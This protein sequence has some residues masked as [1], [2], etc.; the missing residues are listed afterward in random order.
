MQTQSSVQYVSL[1]YFVC[2]QW[3]VH[4]VYIHRY[5]I[6]HGYTL[7]W[8]LYYYIR[9]FVDHHDLFFV[10]AGKPEIPGKPSWVSWLTLHW[11]LINQK[12][13]CFFHADWSS[14]APIS[15]AGRQDPDTLRIHRQDR[16]ATY[17]MYTYVD[18]RNYIHARAG[19]RLRLTLSTG[20]EWM[21][22][23]TVV[24][25]SSRVSVCC[26]NGSVG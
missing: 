16:V 26:C 11:L 4:I 7:D 17:H 18:R 3:Y 9:W 19:S 12:M 2:V 14:F 21:K 1:I 5:M 24:E 10:F 15:P 8:L 25:R 20:S 13:L 6:I 22:Y 23:A